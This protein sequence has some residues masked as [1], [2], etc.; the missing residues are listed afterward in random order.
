MTQALDLDAYGARI[1]YS[2]PMR[3]DLTT[4]EDVF[5]VT[6]PEPASALFARLPEESGR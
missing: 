6:P 2:G 3:P 5:G 4:L 1:G